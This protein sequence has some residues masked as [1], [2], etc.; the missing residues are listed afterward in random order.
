M[1]PRAKTWCIRSSAIIWLSS[2]NRETLYL[3]SLTT[4][5]RDLLFNFIIGVPVRHSLNNTTKK[6]WISTLL[7]IRSAKPT[8]VMPVAFNQQG[9]DSHEE[10]KFKYYILYCCI[11]LY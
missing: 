6:G 4:L 11:F 1:E 7:V 5:T 2:V 10:I 9:M 3:I 8:S